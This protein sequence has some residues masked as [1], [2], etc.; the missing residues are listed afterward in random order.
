M[1]THGV[2]DE[3]IYDILC[4]VNQ[5]HL[6][7]AAARF[8]RVSE[9]PAPGAPKGGP[10]RWRGRRDNL[11]GRCFERILGVLLE[12]C[13]TFSSWARVQ[14]TTNELDWLVTLS[15]RASWLPTLRLRGTHFLCECKS[16]NVHVRVAWVDPMG[17]KIQTHGA[18][19]GVDLEPERRGPNGKPTEGG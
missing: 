18:H 13:E 19:V 10:A 14:S 2:D 17:T 8:T 4:H 1:S 16:E 11:K 15:P 6:H 7:H 12:G 9:M 5:A 3:R